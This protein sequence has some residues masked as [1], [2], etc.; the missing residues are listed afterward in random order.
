MY[1]NKLQM[2]ETEL[3]DTKEEKIKLRVLLE[4]AE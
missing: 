2:K 4:Q 3:L 1:E